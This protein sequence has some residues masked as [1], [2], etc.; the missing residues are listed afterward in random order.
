V[1]VIRPVPETP[2]IEEPRV[3]RARAECT[4]VDLQQGENATSNESV[5]I[6]HLADLVDVAASNRPVKNTDILVGVE[7]ILFGMIIAGMPDKPRRGAKNESIP[8]R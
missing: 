1:R 2:H 8:S 4:P 5:H 6:Q 7:P 3:R